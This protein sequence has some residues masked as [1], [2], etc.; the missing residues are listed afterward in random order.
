MEEKF[1]SIFPG[2]EELLFAASVKL[3]QFA[4][5]A[6]SALTSAKELTEDEEAFL[7]AATFWPCS[8][9]SVHLRRTN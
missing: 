4:L 2:G 5:R 1:T 9:G 6:S 7:Q 3:F 8:F